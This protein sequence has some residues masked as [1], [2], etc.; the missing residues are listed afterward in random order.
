MKETNY[1]ESPLVEI[2][3]LKLE[4]G[5]A[6]SEIGNAGESGWEEL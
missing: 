6:T 4:K 2:T 3:L 5:F 1:Y